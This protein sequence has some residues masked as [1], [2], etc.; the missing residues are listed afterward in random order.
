MQDLLLSHSKKI[1]SSWYL[2]FISLSGF[3]VN[4][5][6]LPPLVVFLW[7]WLLD[8]ASPPLAESS[9][10]IGTKMICCPYLNVS[11]LPLFPWERWSAFEVLADTKWC[12]KHAASKHWWKATF[13]VLVP[14]LLYLLLPK[15]STGP[16]VFCCYI[17]YGGKGE[18]NSC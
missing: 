5:E 14:T 3:Q 10:F 8:W 2:L 18:V 4:A 6:S 9:D 15:E 17:S 7:L 11:A 12:L 16:A 13:Y 1:K